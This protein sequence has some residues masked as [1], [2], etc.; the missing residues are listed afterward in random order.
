[1]FDKSSVTRKL[2]C[3]YCFET[4]L[5]WTCW[6]KKVN[7]QRSWENYT[8]CRRVYPKLSRL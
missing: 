5:I 7:Y 6:C 8:T 2:I 1:M 3:E 4:L